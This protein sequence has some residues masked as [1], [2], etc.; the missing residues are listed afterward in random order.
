MIN[1]IVGL[2]AGLSRIG[3]P[4]DVSTAAVHHG[5]VM[6]GG[7]MGALISLEK[8]LPLKKNW[9][10]IVPLVCAAT[11]VLAVNSFHQVGLGFLL[12]GSIGLLGIQ[13]WYLIRFPRER[14]NAIMVVGA[15]CLVAGNSMLISTAFY[16]SALPWWIGFILFTIVGE[17]LELSKFLPVSTL[18]KKLLVGV[19][20]MF[21]IGLALP[22]HNVGKYLSG[23]ALAAVALWLLRYDTIWIGIKG[24]G[25]LK[26][27]ATA[28]L[29][30]NT[31][32]MVEGVFLIALPDGAFSYDTLVHVFFLGFAF[33]MIFAHGPIIL[34]SVLGVVGKPYHKILYVWLGLLQASLILRV[35][36]NTVHQ[37]EWRR[38]SGA[39]S[40]FTILAYFVTVAVLVFRNRKPTASQP[41]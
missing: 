32:L 5:A 36:G 28:L 27:S 33:T 16:P 2:L 11:P 12:A 17:R 39:L 23:V 31:A 19:L 30:A 14:S 7:F 21:I 3:W 8:A 37:M 34:P 20:L 10:L 6:V 25:L 22:F 4:I 40:A 26:F 9:L 1:L 35:A 24:D 18:A 13:S 15:C 38:V 29:V 41:A